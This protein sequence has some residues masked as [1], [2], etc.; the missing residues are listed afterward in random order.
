MAPR[1]QP[2][3]QVSDTSPSAVP[4]AIRA[5]AVYCASRLPTSPRIADDARALGRLL[6]ERNLTLVYGGANVGLMG[7]VA[8]AALER[9]GKVIG[10]MPERLR[11]R[12]ISHGKLSELKIVE[13][14]HER[15]MHMASLADAFV[16]LPGGLGTLDELFEVATWNQIGIHS[17]PVILIN[18]DGFY[19]PLMG[20][21][22]H[23]VAA[24]ALSASNRRIL[25]LADNAEAALDLLSKRHDP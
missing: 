16:A 20:F 2:H 3:P 5:V 1:M 7:L 10:V 25:T 23:A 6:A 21:L 8:D 4:G 14:M 15:K 17:K 12:E 9:D 19:T 24:G 13:T 18:S 22:D 11:E